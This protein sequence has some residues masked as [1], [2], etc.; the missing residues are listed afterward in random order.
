M[1]TGILLGLL[2]AFANGAICVALPAVLAAVPSKRKSMNHVTS[3][4]KSLN[5]SELITQEAH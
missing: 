5:Q 2:L 3:V 1:E 4:S